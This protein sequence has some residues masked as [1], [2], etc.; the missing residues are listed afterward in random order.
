MRPTN[1]QQ[2]G[3]FRL[4]LLC[5]C[6]LWFLHGPAASALPIPRTAALVSAVDPIDLVVTGLRVLGLMLGWYLLIVLAVQF[7]LSAVGLRSRVVDALTPK[8]VRQALGIGL[9]LAT[10]TPAVSLADA[11]GPPVTMV[12]VDDTPTPPAQSQPRIDDTSHQADATT[13]GQRDDRAASAP[14]AVLIRL[15]PATTENLPTGRSVTAWTVTAGDSFWEIAADTV[16]SR[17]N[18]VPTE[19]EIAD[20]WRALVTRNEHRLIEPGN[21]DLIIPGQVF[22]LPG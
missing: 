19:G 8:M 17:S 10:L 14:P 20:Y 6:A 5:S 22:D 7:A 2:L 16:A 18:A 4:G 13:S 1:K 12:R 11:A 9:G 15:E 21:P 3:V